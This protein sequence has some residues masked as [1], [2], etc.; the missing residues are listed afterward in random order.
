MKPAV[1]SGSAHAR[2]VHGWPQIAHSSTGPPNSAPSR[3]ALP[4][5]CVSRKSA[6][7]APAP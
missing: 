5:I 7:V 1:S 2:F 6:S 3:T 4:P